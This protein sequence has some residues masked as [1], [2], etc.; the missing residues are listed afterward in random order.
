MP[1][2]ELKDFLDHKAAYYQSRW[3]IDQDPVQIPHLFSKKEDIEIAAFFAATLAWGKRASILIKCHELMRGMDMAPHDFILNASPRERKG[4]S[5][6][7]Y[8]TFNS[9]DLNYF[10]TALHHIYRQHDG[11]YPL[12]LEGFEQEGIKGALAHFRQIFFSFNPPG[13]TGKH[14][15]NILKNSSAKRLNMFLRW[16]VR[17]DSP[18]DFGLWPKIEVSQLLIPLDLH[19]GRVARSLNLLSRKQ[20]DFK[21]VLELTNRLAVFRPNDPVFY[22]YALFGL[23]VYEKF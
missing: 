2:D 8:R 20:N 13:R 11:L 4:L 6:F 16:M 12:F 15:A 21:S 23:G 22:D 10:F 9:V 1:D 17:P 18:V 19:V 5:S 3:F 7:V 14:V